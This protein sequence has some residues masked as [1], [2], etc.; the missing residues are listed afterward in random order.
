MI[1]RIIVKKLNQILEELNKNKS[2][3]IGFV[4][5]TTSK[6]SN[7]KTI[8]LPIRKTNYGIFGAVS[9]Y[10]LTIG[11]EI[12][13]FLDGKID[14]ILVDGENKLKQ[15]SNLVQE[16]SKITSKTPVMS[17][18]NND[19]TTNSADA[20]ISFLLKNNI[21]KKIS[22]I[23]L[24]NI[25]TKLSLKL[26]E[27]GFEVY[28]ASKNLQRTK[29][30]ALAL[31]LIK[32]RYCKSKI[33]P[34]HLDNVTQNSDLLVGFS[35]GPSYISTEIIEKMKNDSILI[36]GG[37]GTIDKEGIKKAKSKNIQIYRLD[38]RSGFISE[39][40]LL[41]ENQNFIHNIS[42]KK[43]LDGITIVA[44]GYYGNHGDI[45][46]DDIKK[47]TT[48]IGIADGFGGLIKK[49]FTKSMIEKK[50]KIKSFFKIS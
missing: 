39:V 20:L 4:I 48:I 13:K 26:V 32:P 16:I 22:I 36:D 49:N 38:I 3:K 17:F 2:K 41:F 9:I 5:S 18:K 47:P 12:A 50:E 15:L 10:D 30:I 7:E 27:R 6:F 44:G 23:G 43:T 24:G 37:V 14:V 33:Y 42:G 29:K 11:K 19:L 21:T 1:N 46:V 25:G 8:F 35:S 45:I 34:T 31:N 28:V 40:T